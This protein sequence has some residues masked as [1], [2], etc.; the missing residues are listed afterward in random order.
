MRTLTPDIIAELEAS[1]LTPF[2]GLKIELEGL[3]QRYTDCDIPLIISG[4]FYY[5]RKFSFEAI[6]YSMNNVVDQLKLKVDDIDEVLKQPFADAVVQGTTVEL[7]QALLDSNRNVLSGEFTMFEGEIDAWDLD[8]TDV[9][10]TIA[11][12]FV[13][14]SQQTLSRHS[15]SCRW[16]EFAGTECGY[17]GDDKWCDRSYTRCQAL[18]NTANFGG[19][20]FL[21]ALM[22]KEVWWGSTQS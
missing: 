13:Q 18:N 19:F 17:S 1:E 22:D 9:N 6:R 7:K 11:S 20:R 8:E 4:E 12:Q 10:M 15:A 21:P 14:W 5:P 3:E 16:K 2:Y